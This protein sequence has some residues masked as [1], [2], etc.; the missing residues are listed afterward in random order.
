MLEDQAE[1]VPVDVDEE[2]DI[3]G[4]DNLSSYNDDGTSESRINKDSDES[5]DD[6]DDER[7]GIGRVGE[8]GHEAFMDEDD[9]SEKSS[10]EESDEEQER[11]GKKARR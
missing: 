7:H 10:K 5:S 11:S 9:S 3:D 4:W 8:A 6:Y 1:G 2:P